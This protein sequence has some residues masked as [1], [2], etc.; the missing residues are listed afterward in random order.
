MILWHR[1][2]SWPESV[3]LAGCIASTCIRL[4]F[5]RRA[6]ANR[7]AERRHDASERA[8]V[9]GVFV[10]MLVLPLLSVATPLLDF[11]AYHL[12]AWTPVIGTFLQTAALWL[13]WRSHADLGRNWS[14]M[15][16][17]R[18]DHRLVTE[19]VY[20][21]VRHPMYAGIWLGVLAQPL[22]LQNW[23]SG[24]PVIAA[25]ALLSLLRIPREEA[26]LQDRF[27]TVWVSYAARTGRFLP[28]WRR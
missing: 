12:P 13:F 26:M 18:S 14:P 21:R 7:I 2:P 24:P 22:L 16:E 9:L 20:R 4:L 5:A 27:G 15:L 6:H 3:W 11:A 17:L 28:K 25:F 19:G 8:L 23:L 10:T 1:L